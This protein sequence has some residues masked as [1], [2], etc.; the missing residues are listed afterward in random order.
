MK[1]NKN[2]KLQNDQI[3]IKKIKVERKPLIIQINNKDIKKD[4][5]KK[6]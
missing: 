2:N 1:N 3:V 4:D 6:S 5:N